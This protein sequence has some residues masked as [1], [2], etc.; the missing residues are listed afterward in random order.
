MSFDRSE[1]NGYPRRSQLFA[2]GGLGDGCQPGATCPAP[3]VRTLAD[4]GGP[5][6]DKLTELV[7][8]TEGPQVWRRVFHAAWG[9]ALAAFIAFAPLSHAMLITIFASAGAA[10]LG[11]DVLRLSVPRA[12]ALF[13]RLFRWFASPREEK[14]FASSTWYV[15]GALLVLTLF[16]PELAIPSILVLALADPAASYLG[17]RWGKRRLGTGSVLGVSVFA[18]VATSMLL[19]FVPPSTAAFVG[20]LVALIECQPLGLDDNLTV[21]MG[22]ALGLFLTSV[23]LP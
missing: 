20:C 22:T 16:G 7:Q 8:R 17:R 19:F 21:P 9:V 23:L 6:S 10:L 5:P 3:G 11:V 1:A 14:G 4:D 12:N 18:L 13:F 2:A 15:I